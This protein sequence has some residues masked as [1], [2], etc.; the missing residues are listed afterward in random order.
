VWVVKDGK[1]QGQAEAE[2]TRR[3]ADAQPYLYALMSENE[4]LSRCLM[5]VQEQMTAL[6]AAI[7]SDDH[8]PEAIVIPD[9]WHAREY[10]AGEEGMAMFNDVIIALFI[11]RH[12]YQTETRVYPF[13]IRTHHFTNPR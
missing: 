10:F 11:A 8:L 4:A 2:G 6:I 13:G 5:S 12:Y 3:H 1:G 7:R 9:F